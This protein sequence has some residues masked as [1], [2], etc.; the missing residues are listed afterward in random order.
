MYDNQILQGMD[1]PISSYVKSPILYVKSI[2]S[3]HHMDISEKIE[4]LT[5][6][7]STPITKSSSFTELSTYEKYVWILVAYIYT[8][9]I[10]VDGIDDIPYLQRTESLVAVLS[11]LVSG[12][13]RLHMLQWDGLPPIKPS[14]EISI[15]LKLIKLNDGDEFLRFPRPGT[16]YI[17]FPEQ[18]KYMIDNFKFTSYGEDHRLIMNIIN[19][20]D[21][22]TSLWENVYIKRVNRIKLLND[23]DSLEYRMIYDNNSLGNPYEY[24]G[25]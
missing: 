14:K 17:E 10:V 25:R 6:I 23:T 15:I 3:N 11:M 16:F 9:S 13:G 1:E 19:D 24:H 7:T 2:W 18:V 21:I 4:A 20:V 12:H 22:D 8:T 5:Y